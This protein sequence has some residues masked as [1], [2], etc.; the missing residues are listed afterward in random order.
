MDANEKV[1]EPLII[2]V[3]IY[4][5]NDI[6]LSSTNSTMDP[7][8]FMILFI[9]NLHVFNIQ[10]RKEE[11]YRLQEFCMTLLAKLIYHLCFTG[12]PKVHTL[13]K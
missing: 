7:F 11:R 6:H 5:H 13:D 12:V 2:K 4:R 1:Q 3:D 8:G 10:H 9:W